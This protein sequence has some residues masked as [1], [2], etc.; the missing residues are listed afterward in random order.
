MA[1]RAVGRRLRV[2]VSRDSPGAQA[3]KGRRA[4]SLP[5]SPFFLHSPIAALAPCA[6]WTSMVQ[7]AQLLV[8]HALPV[9]PA[10][11]GVNRGAL[12]IS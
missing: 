3:L 2:D 6:A 9:N 11:F 7:A 1:Q 8:D 10:R 12:A 4:A 5:L